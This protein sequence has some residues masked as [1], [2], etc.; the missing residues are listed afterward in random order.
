MLLTTRNSHFPSGGTVERGISHL[1]AEPLGIH[2]GFTYS[3]QGW[4]A[5]CWGRA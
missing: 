5:G 3:L 2:L 4:T 1:M